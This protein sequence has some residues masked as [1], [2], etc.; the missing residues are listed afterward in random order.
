M[1]KEPKIE[2]HPT[3]DIGTQKRRIERQ[4]VLVHVTVVSLVIFFLQLNS[5]PAI[6]AGFDDAVFCSEAEA[7]KEKGEVDVGKMVDKFTRNDGMAVLCGIKTI[8]FK[9]FLFANESEMRVGWQERKAAQ[10][11]AIYCEGANLEAIKNGWTI[12]TSFI[13]KDGKRFWH[14]ATCIN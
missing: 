2:G 9:K 7:F 1:P 11:D 6:A 10:W 13:A 4:F 14:A 3:G 5:F 12:A 8:E